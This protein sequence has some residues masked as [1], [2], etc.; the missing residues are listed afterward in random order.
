MKFLKTPLLILCLA[1]TLP[2]WGQKVKTRTAYVRFFSETPVENIEAITEQAS[3]VIDLENGQFAFLI[4]IKSFTFEKALMQEHFNEN[5]ME[6][7]TYPNATFKGSIVD[8]APLDLNEDGQYE[9]VMKG[10]MT[11]HGVDRPVEEPVTL[12]V[13]DGKLSLESDFTVKASDYQIKI[14]AAKKDNISN[15]LAVT[16]KADYEA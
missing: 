9:A 7:A 8:Y 14:P 2:L 10:T 12:V 16:V 6:S 15:E 13:N 11:I 4:P 3:S 5:Y 1:L